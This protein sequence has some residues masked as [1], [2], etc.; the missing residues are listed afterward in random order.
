MNDIRV[1]NTGV[2]SLKDKTSRQY[3]AINLK[4]QFGFLPEVIIINKSPG[5]NNRFY[6]SAVMTDEELQKEEDF[7]KKLG[8]GTKKPKKA[9]QPQK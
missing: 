6:V 4:R 9:K 1:K 8:I 5:Q 3:Q 2:F 7:K